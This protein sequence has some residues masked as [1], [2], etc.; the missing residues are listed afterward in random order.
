MKILIISDIHGSLFHL[1]EVLSLEQEEKFDHIIILGD[2][3]NKTMGSGWL[4]EEEALAICDLLNS[5]KAKIIAVRGNC[6][7]DFDMQYLDFELSEYKI[8]KINERKWYLSHGHQN[9]ILPTIKNNDILLNGHSHIF[10]LSKNFI[11]PGSLFLPRSD[12]TNSYIIYENNKFCLYE[13]NNHSLIE[14][15]DL[16]S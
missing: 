13:L 12:T 4:N 14:E 16:N 8:I 1:K 3:L 9:H 6:D 5:F 2:I 10:E 15:L 7:T 11:N